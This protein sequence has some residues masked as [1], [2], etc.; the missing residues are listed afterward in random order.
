MINL[1]RRK[2]LQKA[3]PV[4]AAATLPAL[5]LPVRRASAQ[6]T[7]YSNPPLSNE[8]WTKDTVLISPD[9][10]VRLGLR[11][12]HYADENAPYMFHCYNLEHKGQGM[13]GQFVVV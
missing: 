5:F 9:E 8:S 2:L 6:P 1:Q 11:F 13:M 7:S 4:T 10:T 3:A 12:E